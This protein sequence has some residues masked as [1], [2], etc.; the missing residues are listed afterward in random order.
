VIAQAM[1]MRKAKVR[2]YLREA[3]IILRQAFNQ[4]GKL[5]LSR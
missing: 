4:D 1:G 5:F 3:R 2:Q